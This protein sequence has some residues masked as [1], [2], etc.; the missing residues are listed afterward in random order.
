MTPDYSKIVLASKSPV[1]LDKMVQQCGPELLE[2][3]TAAQYKPLNR[4]SLKSGRL[5]G[6]PGSNVRYKIVDL[7]GNSVVYKNLLNGRV[8]YAKV[9]ELLHSWE[10][11]KVVEI[12]PLQELFDSIKKMLTPFLGA[13]LVGALLNWLSDKLK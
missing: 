6:S 12:T 5:F 7:A 9:E 11:Q 10:T 13:V 4:Y 1:L 8:E 2:K 3:A